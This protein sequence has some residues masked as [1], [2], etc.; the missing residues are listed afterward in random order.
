[1]VE[2]RAS[3]KK[4]SS[5]KYTRSRSS[6]S[7]EEHN[8]SALAD[9]AAQKN[10]CINWDQTT[11]L[12]ARCDNRKGRWIREAIKVRAEPKGTMNRDEGNYKLS[13][14]WDALLM[15]RGNPPTGVTSS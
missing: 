10:H 1:M 12:A 9:H 3:V 7:T 15:S 2:H 8:D 13:R 14:T 4:I 6:K 5:L 11:I